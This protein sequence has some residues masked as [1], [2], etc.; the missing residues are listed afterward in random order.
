ML[1]DVVF[2]A[3]KNKLEIGCLAWHWIDAFWEE[4]VLLNINCLNLLHTQLGPEKQNLQGAALV[5]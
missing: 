1:L 3:L 2:Q 5:N 4:N